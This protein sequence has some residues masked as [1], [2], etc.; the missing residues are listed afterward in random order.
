MRGLASVAGRLKFSVLKDFADNTIRGAAF[1]GFASLT[2]RALDQT[3]DAGG[4]VGLAP[5]LLN[6][7]LLFSVILSVIFM[8]F[9]T[10][11]VIFR[12]GGS[13]GNWK[14][15]GRIEKAVIVVMA[16]GG[17]LAFATITNVVFATTLLD[18]VKLLK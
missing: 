17:G 14:E 15:L 3:R 13:S 9:A 6:T 10:G 8:T 5:F 4:A 12:I 16:V 2:W 7:G 1:V 11:R 18:G